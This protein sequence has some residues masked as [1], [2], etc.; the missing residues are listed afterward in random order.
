M[1]IR[2]A[3]QQLGQGPDVVL[4][5]GLGASRAFWFA[6]LALTLAASH[7]VTIYD[8]RGHGYSERPAEGYRVADHRDD[9]LGLLDELGIRQA[10]LIGHSLGGSIAL[11][12]AVEAPDRVSQLALLDSRIQRL[13]PTLRWQ[14]VQPLSAYELAV[15]ERGGGDW[16]AEPEVGL[17]F[18]EASARLMVQAQTDGLRDDFT[19]FG[20]GRGARR[21]AR[22]FLDLLDRTSL[23]GDFALPGAE[24]AAYAR[25]TMPTLLLYAA[26]SRA[27]ISAETLH[28]AL[29][30]AEWQRLDSAGHFFPI[31]HPERTAIAVR[32]LLERH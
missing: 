4:I 19:P 12:A 23:R 7:R 10:A 28:R 15:A 30:R 13:Q 21:G 31:T 6:R 25:A 14:D 20:E 27:L 2:L 29:P 9:L 16:L 18:I 1:S 22:Q 32:A 3:H 24:E 8:L 11:E 17:R 5:H 26:H